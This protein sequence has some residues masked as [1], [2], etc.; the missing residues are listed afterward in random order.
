M[1]YVIA[2]PCINTK[3]TACVESARLIVST[4]ERTK[5][6]SPTF[7]CFTSTRR[8]YRLRGLRAGLSCFRHLPSG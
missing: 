1:A 4:P 5:P 8:V 2:E 3:D 6:T 7:R